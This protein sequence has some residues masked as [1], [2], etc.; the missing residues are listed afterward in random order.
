MRKHTTVLFLLILT[1]CAADPEKL[2]SV[3]EQEVTRLA[4]PSKPLSAFSD[5]ELKPFVLWPEVASEAEKIR[6]AE[7]LEQAVQAKLL[8]LFSSWTAS[9]D[10]ER[11]GTLIVQ[12]EVVELRIVSGGARFWAGIF[13]GDSHIDMDLK[14]ID[15]T[16][17]ELI[18]KPRI[19]RNAGAWAGAWSIGKSDDNLH[20]YIA[21]ITHEYLASNY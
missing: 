18:A 10:P 13:A 3:A 21:H 1:A 11:S 20:E 4:P 15:A 16:T 6:E 2:N 12:P 17:E 14:L 5:Y 8:P 19:N 9:D 7:I